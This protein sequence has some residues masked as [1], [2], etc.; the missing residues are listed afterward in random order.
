[1]KN[2]VITLAVLLAAAGAAFGTFYAMNDAPAIRRAADEGDAM[3][4]LRAEFHLSDAQF[5]AIKRLHDDYALVC[6]RHC[7]AIIRARQRQAPAAEIAGLERTCVEAM[8]THFRQ[9]AAL[10]PPDEGK[11]Y[12]AIV[13]PRVADFDHH[14]APDLQVHP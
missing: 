10:M 14:G 12:L 11:R 4:W 8:T 13:L 7:R 6:T 5:A 1:M 2:L 9:V 3:A